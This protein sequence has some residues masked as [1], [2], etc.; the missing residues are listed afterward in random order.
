MQVTGIRAEVQPRETPKETVAEK[1]AKLSVSGA[2]SLEALAKR[3]PDSKL[4]QTLTEMVGR[5]PR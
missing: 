4:K 5:K 1:H 3:L 2:E